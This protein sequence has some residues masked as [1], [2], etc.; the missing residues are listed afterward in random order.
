MHNDNELTAEPVM[1]GETARSYSSDPLSMVPR[2]LNKL[3][4]LWVSAT[5]PF[6]KC[7]SRL[8]I[9]C[10]VELLRPHAAHIKLGNDVLIGKDAW[11]NVAGEV[12]CHADPAIVIDDG[13]VIARR[14]QISARNSIHLERDVM[15]AASVIIM[16][17]NHAFEDISRPICDQG[18][19]SGGRIRIEAGCW[20]GHGAAILCDR[21]DL[22]I[23]RNSV[24][25]ANAV[26]T[27]GCPPYSVLSGNPARVVKQFD[28]VKQA[29]VLGSSRSASPELDRREPSAS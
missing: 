15:L 23:G 26:V 18:V 2:I 12:D 20:I 19:T 24:V 9:H 22:V 28:P 25:A 4:S 21:E 8:S 16:D 5:Y 11:L 17:H 27:R 6:A 29:W 14:A 7:G 13:C 3:Y 10:S 1:L